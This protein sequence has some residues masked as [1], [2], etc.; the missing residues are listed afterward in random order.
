MI[1]LDPLGLAHSWTDCP[2]LAAATASR[3]S[4]APSALSVAT[5]P[6]GR[7]TTI[8]SGIVPP[9]PP[10]PRPPAPPPLP[11]AAPLPS[12]PAS[13]AAIQAS[14]AEAR[15]GLGP[16]AQIDDG[17]RGEKQR[18]RG[19][20]SSPELTIAVLTPAAQI[21]RVEDDAR[22]RASGGEGTYRAATALNRGREGIAQLVG[23]VAVGRPPQ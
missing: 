15:T 6:E 14:L 19:R 9:V 3:M 11:P 22:M 20:I 23:L 16:S 12:H 7:F 5:R 2:A 1:R 10:A 21:P 18:V 17:G 4:H 8:P 13:A